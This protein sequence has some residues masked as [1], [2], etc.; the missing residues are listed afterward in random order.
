VQAVTAPLS[1]D[2]SGL[3]S[4]SGGPYAPL[5]SPL[6]TGTPKSPTPATADSS[7]NIAST[8]FVKAAIAAAVRPRN[9]IDGGNFVIA[10]YPNPTVLGIAAI[11]CNDSTNTVPIIGPAISKA[12]ATP[13]AAGSG[14]GALAPGATTPSLNLYFQIF[15]A[16]I[17]GAYDVFMDNSVT[18]AHA[19]PGTTAFRRIGQ[20]MFDGATAYKPVTQLG[21]DFF[22][23][24][25]TVFNQNVATSGPVGCN[26]PGFSLQP[27]LQGLC[28]TGAGAA[29]VTVFVQ[30]Q[31]VPSCQIPL[32]STL[33]GPTDQPIQ[34]QFPLIKGPPSNPNNGQVNIIMSTT[35]NGGIG[36]VNLMGWH[37]LRGRS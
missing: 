32:G 7:T 26:A 15:A 21:E 9:F 13:W 31:A 10:T 5:A 18:A 1:V 35:G 29:S 6:F 2:A 28:S 12:L 11:D 17:N 25:V 20:V 24:A 22:I 36:V 16:I 14:N 34:N 4:L 37:D 27:F 19:P 30:S 8:A 23:P 33:V 3:L